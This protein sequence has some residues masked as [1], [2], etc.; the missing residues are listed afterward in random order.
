MSTDGRSLSNPPANAEP[1]RAGFSG[2]VSYDVQGVK[3][4]I[5]AES[6][7]VIAKQDINTVGDVDG[8]IDHTRYVLQPF[9][10]S[11][12]IQFA[13]D[14]SQSADSFAV[15]Q[16]LYQ[17]AVL[18]RDDGN[19]LSRSFDRELH[20]RYYPGFSYTYLDMAINTFK[21][22][23]SQGDVLKASV[24]MMGRGR[25]QMEPGDSPNFDA[26]DDLAPVRVI[27]Y[28]DVEIEI[29]KDGDLDG[30]GGLGDDIISTVVRSFDME[31]NNNCELI[32][33]LSNAL[34]PYD[35]IAKK[36]EITGS[37]TFAGKQDEL[38]NWAESHETRTQSGCDLIFRVKFNNSTTI[39]L[40]KLRGVIFQIE[41]VSLTNDLIET[42]CNYRAYG[43]QAFNFEAI[44]GFG[45]SSGTSANDSI[46]PFDA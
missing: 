16:Q 6:C 12:N 8:A 25:K 22:S 2:A 20:V 40:F 30:G 34:T 46:L 9:D 24:S 19:L 36:R 1:V 10:I 42:T 44:S 28:N 7:D 26:S 45:T 23:V 32:H 43:H 14:Q 29:K 41:S 31:I 21:L 27:Q 3:Y 38:A 18:R 17:D 37:V 39:D 15:F 33:T 35:I 4:M 11:G 13:L 5:R